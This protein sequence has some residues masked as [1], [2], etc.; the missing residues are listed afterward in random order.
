MDVSRL[1]FPVV[2]L[3]TGL[4]LG[5][6]SDLLLYGRPAGISVLII[7]ALVVLALL[8][9]AIVEGM[10]V[11]WSNLWLILPLLF[12]AIM[13]MVR[14]EPTLRF[15]NISGALLLTALLANGLGTRPLAARNVGGYLEALLEGS[16]LSTFV[17]PFMLLG[18]SGKHTAEHGSAAGQLVRR[19]L[20]GALIAAP[21]LCLFTCL[22]SAADMIFEARIRNILENLSIPDLVGHA[23]LTVVLSWIICGGLAYALSRSPEWLGMFSLTGRE[24]GQADAAPENAEGTEQ[25]AQRPRLKPRQL[26]GILES[27]IVLFSVDALFLV[28]VAIQFAALFGGEAFLRSQG[29]TYSE[30]ARR[31]FFELLAVSLITL[32]L[33]LSLEFITRR[34][35]QRHHLVFMV[36]SGLMIATTIIIL[37]SAWL[38]LQLYEEAYGFTILRVYPHVFMVWLA[39]LFAFLL[40]L[41][42]IRKPRYVATGALL[43]AIGFVVTMNIM[44]PDAFIV[45]QNLARYEAGEELDVGYLGSLSEDAVPHLI[46]LLYDYGPEIGAEIGPWLHYHLDQLDGR[47]E[48]AGWPSYHVSINRAYRTLA[49]NRG[50]IEQ[51]ELPENPW[52][53]GYD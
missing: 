34:E 48:E 18:R 32:A 12:G 5:L 33:I 30:Y 20:I 46:P 13:S 11:V 38:R 36:G 2:V 25:S 47:Q 52:Y 44:N 29:L 31:G 27:S 22:F 3:I 26:L 42:I 15:L 40:I 10:K 41:L 21:F 1:K 37:A 4:G 14:A 43:A 23:M 50:L 17:F 39:V 35:T 24:G 9:L 16:I 7:F 28:F 8:V 6:I 53:Y 19:I 49:A 51:F 45:R